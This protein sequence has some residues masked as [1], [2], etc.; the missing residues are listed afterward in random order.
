MKF[1]GSHKNSR[2]ESSLLFIGEGNK[3]Q[4]AI[5][6]FFVGRNSGKIVAFDEDLC[7][8]THFVKAINSAKNLR[9]SWEN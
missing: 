3:L 7:S 8:L 4:A 2:S 6:T 5:E 1:Y 9:F